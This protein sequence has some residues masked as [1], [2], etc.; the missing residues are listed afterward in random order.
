MLI[1]QQDIHLQSMPMLLLL[2]GSSAYRVIV[3][4]DT[5]EN[6]LFSIQVIDYDESELGTKWITFE[7][8]PFYVGDEVWELDYGHRIVS[9]RD[10]NH[11]A[12]QIW[13]KW[14]QRKIL[15]GHMDRERSK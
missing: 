5:N 13:R 9:I 8:Y 15:Q 6:R 12:W 3:S 14:Q 10:S 4:M 1:S 2:P 11:S 7:S